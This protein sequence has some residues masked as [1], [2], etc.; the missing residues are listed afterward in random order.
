M[1][2]IRR[3]LFLL[4]FASAVSALWAEDSSLGN[5][6]GVVIDEATRL[7]LQFVNVT[8]R[9]SGDSTAVTGQITDSAGVFAMHGVPAGE[10]YVTQ[11]M[12]GYRP[13]KSPAFRISPDRLTV[14]LGKIALATSEIQMDEVQISAEKMLFTTSIDRKIYNVER[15]LTGKS[16]SVSELLQHVPSV[17]VD[18]DGNVSLRGSSNVMFMVNG[19]PSPLVNRNSSTVLEQMPANSIER[20]EVLTNPSAEF[21]PDAAAG[22][23]NIVMKKNTTAGMNGSVAGNMGD[24]ERYN[25]NLSLNYNPGKYNLYGSYGIRRNNRNRTTTDDRQQADTSFAF[26]SQR[27]SGHARPLMQTASGGWDYQAGKHDQFGLSGSYFGSGV[28][29]TENA[30]NI[31]SDANRTLTSSYVRNRNQDQSYKEAEVTGFYEHGFAKEEH[32]LRFEFTSSYAPE[33]EDN[34]FTNIYRTPAISNTFDKSR[35]K[36]TESNH[37]VS[38]D[39]AN[40]LSETTSLKAGYS[41]EIQTGDFDNHIENFDA[42][43]QVYVVDTA[44]TNRFRSHQITHALY[45]TWRQSFGKL[46][47]LAGLRGEYVDLTSNLVTL[48]SSISQS[49]ANVYPSLHLSYGVSKPV[50]LQLSYSKRTRRPDIDDLNPFPE[51]SDPRNVRSG[52]PKL[53]PE[54]VHSLELGCQYRQGEISVTPALFYRYTY[55]RFTWVTR[56]LNDSVLLTTHDNLSNDQAGGLEVNVTAGVA[57]VVSLHGT[58]SVYENQI[59]ASNLTGGRRT[60]NTWSSNLTMDI[61]ATETTRLQL[62]SNYR[63]SMLTA[64]GHMSPSYT[65]NAGFRQQFYNGKLSLLVT[66]TDIFHTMKREFTVDTATLHE[67]AVTT[68]DSRVIYAGLTFRF[69]KAPKKSRDEQIRYDSGE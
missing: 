57:K 45:S 65:L 55:N 62:S 31:L 44:K 50:E 41:A 69:G 42:A 16:G 12:I 10:Y 23:I 58:A 60:V 61:N 51:Y 35:L 29:R 32:S 5:I 52:N 53:R 21:K 59:D 47:V 6:Q 39:Y 63:S 17:Q 2:L 18:I 48:D 28:D 33:R 9:K 7:P 36:E 13:R 22:I 40:P 68:F 46:G 56:A 24:S 15:D 43:Q 1:H 25:S 8:L 20:I 4:S 37:Q 49:Y 64:Q 14:N 54:Y 66:V 38:V 27:T 26:L 19:R 67:T 30:D 11:Q 3:V 34:Q